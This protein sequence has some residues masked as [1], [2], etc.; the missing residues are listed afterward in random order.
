MTV[1]SAEAVLL[2]ASLVPVTEY[3]VVAAGL[4]VQVDADV[5]A[6]LPPVQLYVV[7]AGLQLAVKT[8]DRLGEIRGGQ[9]VSVQI[10]ALDGTPVPLSVTTCGLPAALLVTRATP[11]RPR[12]AVGVN[13]IPKLHEVLAA[14]LAP[15]VLLA[16]A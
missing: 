11:M 6:Q 1:T 14:R 2:P 7:A 9:A 12:V 5:P 13:V 4:T 3:V 15:Q 10:G 16:T 8:D